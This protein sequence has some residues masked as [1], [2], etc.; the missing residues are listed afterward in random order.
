MTK[1]LHNFFT[2]NNRDIYFS[3]FHHP[4]TI[5]PSIHVGAQI[6][7]FLEGACNNRA[8]INVLSMNI[9]PSKSIIC[10]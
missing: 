3:F 5:I 9:N 1:L 2:R 4:D 8:I 10:L 7:H 6:N